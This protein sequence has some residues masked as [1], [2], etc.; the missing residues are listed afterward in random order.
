MNEVSFRSDMK[1]SLYKQNASDNDVAAAAW[2][3]NN[4]D[5]DERI[6]Q[7]GRVEGL[8]NFLWREKHTSPLEHNF[9]TFHAE[10]PIFVSREWVRHRTWSYNEI[11]GRYA[12][13][14]PVFWSPGP[15]RPLLQSGKVGN[16]IFVPGN[17]EQYAITKTN[18]ERGAEDA[19]KR[20][21]SVR[22]IGVANEVARAVLPVGIY[23]KFWAS[24]NALNVLR[25]LTLRNAPNAQY[26]IR[27][28]ARAVE[29]I[30][31]EAMP[32][33]YKAYRRGIEE[34]SK[35]DEI[36]KK[37]QAGLLHEVETEGLI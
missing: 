21:E 4:L 14:E 31:A 28:A 8:I 18:I 20:Y 22:A 26:E 32:L 2:V 35:K 12:K 13:L 19:W 15:E 36:W 6:N 9:F 34:Q 10:V 11:S 33:T 29:E 37:W 7:P 30:F 23:T 17:A 16:Y 25:F 1:I 27:E 3:S 24:A 5:P